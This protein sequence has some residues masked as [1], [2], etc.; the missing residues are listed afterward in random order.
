MTDGNQVKQNEMKLPD[1]NDRNEVSEAVFLQGL[2]D[3][4]YPV[5]PVIIKMLRCWEIESITGN[6]RI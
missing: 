4:F 6:S 2:L 1:E 5:T 3:S